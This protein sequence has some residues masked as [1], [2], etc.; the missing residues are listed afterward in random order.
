M[1]SM[2]PE[3]FVRLIGYKTVGDKEVTITTDLE[4]LKE[5]ILEADLVTGHNIHAFDLRAIFGPGSDVPLELTK[6]GKVFDT[7][8]HAI[9][10]NPA[11]AVYTDRFGNQAIA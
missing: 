11:P 9:L 4:E 3:D 1:F 7:W 8:T 10:V 2:K 5:K 6:A